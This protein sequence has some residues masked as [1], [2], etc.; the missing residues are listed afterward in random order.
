MTC[1]TICTLIIGDTFVFYLAH[2]YLIYCLFNFIIITIITILILYHF[3]FLLLTLP[4]LFGMIVIFPE[5]MSNFP[6]TTS[7]EYFSF[8]FTIYIVII[9][10][11]LEWQTIMVTIHMSFGV[12]FYHLATF[13]TLFSNLFGLLLDHYFIYF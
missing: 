9:F 6:W 2:F 3:F 7:F 13:F 4:S 5:T 10:K 8:Y 11:F 12:W 1:I